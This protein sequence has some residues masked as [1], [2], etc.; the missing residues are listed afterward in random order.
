MTKNRSILVTNINAIKVRTVQSSL[1][2]NPGP[3]SG[4]TCL[5]ILTEPSRA[6]FWSTNLFTVGIAN[7]LKRL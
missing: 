7:L 5:I 3:K 1:G 6:K 4:R 2:V